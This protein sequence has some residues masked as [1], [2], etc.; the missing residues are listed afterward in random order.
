MKEKRTGL[1][2]VWESNHTIRIVKNNWMTIDKK[3]IKKVWIIKGL[4]NTHPKAFTH[5]FGT[6]IA[7]LYG[8][9]SNVHIYTHAQAFWLGKT[10]DTNFSI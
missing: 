9:H 1:Q 5:E 3:S 2:T 7:N 6:Y 8:C 10:T 4:L